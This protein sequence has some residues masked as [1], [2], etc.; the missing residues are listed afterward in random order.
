M[1]PTPTQ[2]G[3]AIG[4]RVCFQTKKIAEKSDGREYTKESLTKMNKT[5]RWSTP[6]GVRWFRDV[7]VAKEAMEENRGRETKTNMDK[8]DKKNNLP[9]LEIRDTMLTR[10]L[11]ISKVFLL[12]QALISELLKLLLLGG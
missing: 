4:S 12:N 2:N 7:K 8:G 9:R 5:E 11:P 6:F 1:D 10:H 3:S